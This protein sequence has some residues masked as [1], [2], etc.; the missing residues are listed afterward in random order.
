MTVQPTNLSL[1]ADQ[2]LV[3]EWSDGQK[4]R[5]KPGDL[6][7]HCPCA[8][9]IDAGSRA[10]ARGEP[11]PRPPENVTF[12]GMVPAG[13]Y[14]YKIAFSDG[15]DTGIYTLELLRRLGEPVE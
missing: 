12:T 7:R 14:A 15:H 11:P 9:C 10:A 2:A 13:N 6:R 8:T 5:Y 1:D 3:I 4:R